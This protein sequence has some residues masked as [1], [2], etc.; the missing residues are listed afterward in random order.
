MSFIALYRGQDTK[1]ERKDGHPLQAY[2]ILVVAVLL[3]A[4][5]GFAAFRYHLTLRI[6]G[7][8]GTGLLL[9]AVASGLASF[10][11]PCSFPLLLVLLTREIRAD[12]EGRQADR[13]L[14]FA[15]GL[16][17]GVSIFLLLAGGAVAFGAAPIF[18]QFTFTSPEG[19]VLRFTV[20]SILI[21]FGLFQTNLVPVRFETI[22]SISR[23]LLRAQARLRQSR[24]VLG[25]SLLG[26]TYILAG[27][28]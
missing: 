8:E 13:A 18:R 11:S 22:A 9:L 6:S 16:A 4:I 19:R 25:F 3:V 12:S 21:L 7:F 14:L 24:P 27:F 1:L 10:F 26:F 23:P 28:G 17:T 15:T 20:G 5:A 2:V